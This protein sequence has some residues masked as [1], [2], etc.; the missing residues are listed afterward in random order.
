MGNRLLKM[1]VF[2]KTAEL[3]S[4]SA[5]A[6]ALEMSAQIVGRHIGE[7]EKHLGVQLLTRTTRKQSLTEAGRLYLAGCKRALAAV[8]EAD[9]TVA[10]ARQVPAGVL[11]ITAPVEIGASVLAPRLPDFLARHSSVKVELMLADRR[12]DLIEE[13]FDV[14]LRIGHLADSGLHARAL[15]PF[16]L[17]TCASPEYLRRCNVPRL[18]EDLVGHECLDY[19]F[20]NHPSPSNWTFRGPDGDMSIHPGVRMVINDGHALVEAALVGAGIIRAS[21]LAVAPLLA[22]GRLV[23]L[24]TD[25]ASEDRPMHLVYP[26]QRYRLPRLRAFVDWA[27]QAL[28]AAHDATTIEA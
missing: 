20:H 2:V 21:A 7:L 14:A 4:F 27:V 18:P 6:S 24:L 25:F 26:P 10:E 13:N 9:A 15:V 23:S 8:E 19:A 1:T 17:V 22:S 28:R 11:R 3:G 5:A 12:V 16:R